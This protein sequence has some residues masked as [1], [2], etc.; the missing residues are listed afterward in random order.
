GHHRR[1]RRD[2]RGALVPSRGDSRDGGTRREWA[3]R[4]DPDLDPG[5]AGDCAPD[6]PEMVERARHRVTQITIISPHSNSIRCSGTR[7]SASTRRSYSIR[8]HFRVLIIGW[9]ELA[10]L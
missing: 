7:I 8:V 10:H 4:P 1:P 9:L 5:A 2:R 3:G 6:L